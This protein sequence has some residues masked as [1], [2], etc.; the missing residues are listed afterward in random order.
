MLRY[1]LLSG[2][3][4]AG[5]GSAA[6]QNVA[7]PPPPATTPAT[8]L[9]PATAPAPVSQF[10]ASTLALSM[11]WGAPYGWGLEYAY[12]VTPNVDVNAGMGIGVGGKIGVGARYYF[13]TDRAFTPYLGANLTRSGRVSNVTLTLDNEETQYSINPSGV[14][15][16]RGGFRWQPGHVGLSGTLGY[17]VVFTG[18]PVEYNPYYPAPS[19]RLRDVVDAISPG[20]I[21]ISIGV[22]FGLGK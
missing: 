3:L 2:L 10:R 21:E 18:D 22:H 12:M 15:N 13:H 7:T 16:L 6:A 1:L 9:L 19:Q 14:L 11:G 8:P 20:G 17:G 5:A 4:A